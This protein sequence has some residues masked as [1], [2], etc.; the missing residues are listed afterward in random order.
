MSDYLDTVLHTGKIGVKTAA[1]N[2]TVA[3]G[4]CC[5]TSVLH[6][7]Q[8]EVKPEEKFTVA[9]GYSLNEPSF[10]ILLLWRKVD[11][12]WVKINFTP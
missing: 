3:A 1:E 12:G 11:F 2:L 5:G 9:A 6:T 7:G 8:V 10:E 4:S